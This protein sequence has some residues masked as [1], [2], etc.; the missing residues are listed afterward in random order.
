MTYSKQD[1]PV[2]TID[3][4]SGAGK[5]TVCQLLARKLGFHYLD[6][7]ALYRLTALAAKREGIDW[8]AEDQVADVAKNMV[9]EFLPNDNGVTVLLDG[10]DS[11]RDI[12]QEEMSL[13]SS[14]VAVHPR[15]RAALLDLQLSFQKAPGLVADGRD[16]GTTVFPQATAK[17][18][19]TASA[20]ARAQRRYKQLVDTNLIDPQ[21]PGHSESDSLRALLEDIEAR[22]LRDSQR[23]SSP[24]KPAEDALMLDSTSLSIDEVLAEVLKYLQ[25]QGISPAKS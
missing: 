22:D 24:L 20:S 3:G 4:P 25:K 6:S 15:V 2:I 18:F 12:R 9:V 16:M 21:L 8:K 7:G 23:S 10:V 13:G 11:T 19:L 17:I 5:G 1:A 14:T